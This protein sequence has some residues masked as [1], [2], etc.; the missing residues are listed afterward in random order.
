MALTM[1]AATDPTYS[2]Q[3]HFLPDI[4]RFVRDTD[5]HIDRQQLLLLLFDN[6]N[7]SS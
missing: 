1:M 3:I 4:I 6:Q 2:H 7:Y 5:R